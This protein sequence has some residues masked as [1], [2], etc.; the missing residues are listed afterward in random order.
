MSKANLLRLTLVISM[1]FELT[2]DP[3]KKVL[4]QKFLVWPL[5]KGPEHTLTLWEV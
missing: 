2:L 5:C 4:N 3:P 1:Q